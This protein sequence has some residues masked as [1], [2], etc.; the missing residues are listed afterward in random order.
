MTKVKIAPSILSADYANLA[1]ALDNLKVWNA[2]WVHCDVMDG[3]FVPNITFGMPMIGAL[4]KHTDM[5][6][7][8]HLMI[9]QPERY[10]P[11]FLKQGADVIT[12]HAEASNDVVGALKTIK[13]AGKK[14]GL[15]LNPDKPLEMIEPYLDYIDVLLIMGVY[16][17][18]GGQGYIA[19]TTEKIRKAKA[20]IGS[21]TIEIELDGGAT[22]KNAAEIIGAG[23]TIL[24]AGSAVFG[25]NNPTETIKK[26][27]G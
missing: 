3:V 10:I 7:D 26:L 17:G 24:V 16:A 5:V 14:C 23:T 18:F 22:E 4:R 25:S 1:E 20:L 21:R 2:D 19:E 9:V 15:V 13:E 6:L 12:F 8:V 27:R 11:E